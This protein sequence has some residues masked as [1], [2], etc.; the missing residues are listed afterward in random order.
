MHE[1]PTADTCQLS[2]TRLVPFPSRYLHRPCF[3][4]PPGCPPQIASYKRVCAESWLWAVAIFGLT[5]LSPTPRYG[6]GKVP[7]ELSDC[8]LYRVTAKKEGTLTTLRVSRRRLCDLPLL[9]KI[10]R[11]RYDHIPPSYTWLP[12]LTS[13]QKSTLPFPKICMSVAV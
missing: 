8:R 9:L 5:T 13:L 6:K 10:L 2:L 3:K 7:H 4:L 12:P 1:T 11:L